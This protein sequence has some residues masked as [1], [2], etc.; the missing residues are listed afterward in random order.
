VAA[1]EPVVAISELAQPGPA[2]EPGSLLV[3]LS[4]RGG[5]LATALADP[6]NEVLRVIAREG[7]ER[8]DRSF[9][10]RRIESAWALRCSLGLADGRSAYRLVNGE[11]DGLGGFLADVYGRFAVVYVFSPAF[12]QL[13]R[14][15]AEALLEGGELDG[16]VLKV[17]PRGGPQPGKVRQEVVGAEPPEKLVVEELGVPYEVH[18][19]GG[20]NVGLFSD[21]REHRRGLGRFVRGRRV[22]NTFAYT[23]AFSVAAARAGAASVTSVDLS[24]GVLKWARENFRLSGLDP[25]EP[26]FCFEASDVSRF[27]DAAAAQKLEYDAI[28]LDPPTFSAARAAAWSMKNDY[29]DLIAQAASLLPPA[30][31]ILWAAANAHGAPRLEKTLAEGIAKCGAEARVLETGGLPPDYPTLAT[32]PQSRYLQVAVLW[33]TRT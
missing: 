29:P 12:L 21:M 33:V 15:L 13:G 20:L 18:L 30:G 10:R 7:I 1:G 16:A 4:A 31:G 2:Q 17:R 19:L 11:G 26:R 32:Y 3:L 27:L 8:V 22:L 23:G 25:D 14:T 9:F 24:S 5:V 28:I 6:D